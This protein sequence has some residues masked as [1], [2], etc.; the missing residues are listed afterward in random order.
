MSK[1][2]NIITTFL[3]LAILIELISFII[4]KNSLLDI[5]HTPKFYLKNNLIPNDEWWTENKSWGAWHKVNASTLQKKSCF[6]VNYSSNEVGARDDSFV[7]NKNDDII[8]VGDSFAEGYGVNLENTS[9]KY[10]EQITGRN[11]LNFGTSL[12][13]GPVQYSILYE[14]LAKKFLH[15]TLIIYLLP[16]NDFG[17]NDFTNWE[18]SKRFRPYYK[19]LSSTNYETF[20]PSDAIK[21]YKSN[22]KKIKKFFSDYF[23]VSNLFIN[24][25][26]NY[27]VFRSKKK[28]LS[29]FSGYYDSSLDQQKAVIFFLDK[30]I[31]IPS[32]EI[33]LVSIP[34]INDFKRFSK[35]SNLFNLYWNSYF[36][37]KDIS[38]NNFKFIDLIKYMPKNY[39]DLFL[40]CDG[41]WSPKGNLWAAKI[42]SQH[43]N[44]N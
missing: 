20:I 43:L 19:L 30:M 25:N 40:T 33:I 4:A 34:R 2:R 21:N 42:I 5:S 26:Y 27:K 23:W 44:K 15:K 11:V 7:N 14:K 8:L 32:L 29:D 12:N 41:H 17:E 28:S 35:E 13:F 3:I 24:I 31:N 6:K 18:G 10:I 37:K 36:A 9:Q 22:T 39:Y 38:N 1:I 16:N